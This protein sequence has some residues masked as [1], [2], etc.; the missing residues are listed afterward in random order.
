MDSLFSLAHRLLT[1]GLDGSPIY[2]DEFTRLNREVYEQALELYGTRGKTVESEAELCLGLLTAFAAT[3]YDNGHKQ[4]YIQR[5]L[6]RSWEVLP[7]LSASLLKVQLLVYCYSEVYDEELSRQAHSI[8]ATWDKAELTL[9]QVDI[10]EE[11]LHDLIGKYY[12]TPVSLKNTLFTRL[13]VIPNLALSQINV[14]FIS[15]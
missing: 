3:I 2:V 15:K 7:K 6:D 9:E 8:I 5:V 10:I 13:H 14:P 12:A 1:Y 11:P 4:Q